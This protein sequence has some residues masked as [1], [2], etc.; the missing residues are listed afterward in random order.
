[1]TRRLERVSGTGCRASEKTQVSRAAGKAQANSASGKAPSC[2]VYRAG[3]GSVI[4]IDDNKL[5]V[6]GQFGNVL[7]KPLP[8]EQIIT[9]L[10]SSKR[11]LQT[12]GMYPESRELGRLFEQCG[13][14]NLCGLDNMSEFEITGSHD[15]TFALREYTR[16]AEYKYK[17]TETGPD[18]SEKDK[19][20]K[21]KTAK[22]KTAE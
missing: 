7:V 18:A 2:R 11:H 9:A 21:D 4:C 10:Y 13:L 1:M 17:T 19:T 6:S 14:T 22:D 8:R 15:G 5:E 12:V 16:I 20:A 3:S